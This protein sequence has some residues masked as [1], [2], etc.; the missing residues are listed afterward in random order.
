LSNLR[1]MENEVAARRI[2]EANAR[3]VCPPPPSGP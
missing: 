3:G 1:G 2:E